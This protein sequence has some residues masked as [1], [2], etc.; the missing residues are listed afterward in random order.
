M[1]V[2][3]VT[4]EE[5]H[6][7]VDILA[8]ALKKQPVKYDMIYG[9]PRGGLVPAVML[10]HMLEIPQVTYVDGD[11]I[12][13]HKVLVVDD[14]VHTSETIRRFENAFDTRCDVA[15]VYL[16]EGCEYRPEYFS[17][18][19]HKGMWIKFPY[20]VDTQDSVSKVTILD[21]KE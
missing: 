14:I 2:R 17:A 12:S 6:A 19:V 13:L 20:E 21:R 8:N 9:I 7:L 15:T 1:N 4:W 5:F 11:L 3:E 18:I 16:K 10:S